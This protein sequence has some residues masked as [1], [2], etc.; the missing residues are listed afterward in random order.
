MVFIPNTTPTPNW[1]YNGEMKKM[2]ETELKVV[3]LVTR[4]TLGW[5]DTTTSERKQQ[6]YISQS[7]FKEFTGKESAAIAQ[8]IQSSVLHGWIIAKDKD[9]NICDTPEKRARRKIWYQLGC[10]FTSKISSSEIKQDKK[11]G[12]VNDKSGSVNA[13]NLVRKANST[14]ETLTKETNTNIVENK[15]ST[16]KV[17]NSKEKINVKDEIELLLSDK[18][19][20]IKIIGLF[21]Q[22]KKYNPKTYGEFSAIIKRNVKSANKIKEYDLNRIEEV[23]NWLKKNADFKWGIE[24]IGK[25][26][27]E[28]LKK[29]EENLVK[30]CHL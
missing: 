5:F 28:D 25:Y 6:D 10:V 18:C 21:I 27:D 26:I 23:A 3:L 11:S 29:L 15:F 4:K 9:N 19:K 8:A 30:E 2:N 12:S 16:R 17:R 1:L 22:A 24:T 20:H 14:K 13:S 7:Q